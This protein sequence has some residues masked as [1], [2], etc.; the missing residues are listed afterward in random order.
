MDL[1]G[2][3]TSANLQ[4]MLTTLD[5][6]DPL[7]YP[8]LQ[9]VANNAF[10]R[11]ENT[12]ATTELDQAINALERVALSTTTPLQ[13]AAGLKTVA[14]WL[15]TR[16]EKF[17]DLNRAVDIA[18]TAA[19]LVREGNPEKIE[20]FL[21]LLYNMLWA[22]GMASTSV[23]DFTEALEVVAELRNVSSHQ[24]LLSSAEVQIR[25]QLHRARFQTLGSIEDLNEAIASFE[26]RLDGADRLDIVSELSV[27]LCQR[28]V[29]NKSIEDLERAARL[30]EEAAK[31]AIEDDKA[32]RYDRLGIVL[33]NRF[34]RTGSMIDLDRS[35]DSAEIAVNAARGHPS[36]KHLSNSLYNLGLALFAR[37]QETKSVRDLDKA[38][39][40][41][42]ELVKMMAIEHARYLK[43][44]GDVLTLKYSMNESIDCL[45]QAI[46]LF[47]T[48]LAGPN[49]GRLV[50]QCEQYLSHGRAL[51]KRFE[52]NGV[53]DDINKCIS[54][55]EEA[56]RIKPAKSPIRRYLQVIASAYASRYWRLRVKN[57]LDRAIELQQAALDEFPED[58]GERAIHL[59]NL[60]SL[61]LSRF[62][63]REIFVNSDLDHAINCSQE[64]VILIKRTQDKPAY[65]STLAA[66]LKIRFERISQSMEDLQNAILIY[67][68]AINKC[69]SDDLSRPSILSNLAIT[70]TLKYHQTKNPLDLDKAIEI[71]E[72]AVNSIE[73]EEHPD[74]GL[75][76]NNLSRTLF[77]RF[78]L[79]KNKDDLDEAY[80]AKYKSL[81]LTT[82]SPSI[83]VTGCLAIVWAL[84]ETQKDFQRAAE[85]IEPAIRLF[86]TITPR[87]Q[88][89]HDQEYLISEYAGLPGTAAA[90]LLEAGHDPAKVLEILEIGRGVI[91]NSQLELRSDIT[92]LEN[93]D[94][95]EAREL[96]VQFKGIRERI[97]SNGTA[98]EISDTR[99]NKA[100]V[101]MKSL[102]R[103]Q[104]DFEFKE[105]VT[106]I[107]HLP[108]LGRFLLGPTASELKDMAKTSSIIALNS[109]PV[110]CDAFIITSDDIKVCPL[111]NLQYSDLK[112]KSMEFARY[113]A[114]SSSI[115]KYP[116]SKRGI[117]KIL[118]WLWDVAVGPVMDFMETKEASSGK[119]WRQVCWMLLIYLA[120]FLYTLLDITE[121]AQLKMSFPVSFRPIPRLSNHWNI[122][123]SD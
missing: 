118:E 102:E 17:S 23:A 93:L 13:R 19:K 63:R 123:K 88:S 36:H 32:L 18:N 116:Q 121:S 87:I 56:L 44:L 76:L 113:I 86:P 100:A 3:P 117:K 52:R 58:H 34:R 48:A 96:A 1:Q 9:L 92:E 114:E 74:R 39:D 64:A 84:A 30:A 80:S 110:R 25:E 62:N 81:N 90:I 20:P 105:T 106:K 82:A 15:Y 4:T 29:Y 54:S 55:L 99:D 97:D 42:N 60:A 68:D 51:Q 69:S 70:L 45:N 28:G 41:G 6:P 16:Y 27:C 95:D 65:L 40:C 109:S 8:L 59:H 57:D 67:E 21:F 50:D 14:S 108:G 38:M 94:S 47:E 91:A 122:L 33:L 112:T 71:A 104:L 107:R 98:G 79:S 12:G 35:I 89:R 78:R 43:F 120:R 73:V 2:D 77:L 85:L 111:P 72:E 75:Y 61:L 49:K 10:T 22:R 66:L 46:E 24:Q 103:N 101:R 83:R 5:E 53:V 11:F 115:R 26:N 119:N 7:Y 31:S 37:V